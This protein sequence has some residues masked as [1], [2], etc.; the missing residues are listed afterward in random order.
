[1]PGDYGI[2]TKGTGGTFTLQETNG[3]IEAFNADGTLNDIQ[4]TNGNRITA[5]YTAGRLTQPGGIERRSATNPVVAS[6]TIG[7]NTAGLIASVASSDGRTVTYTYDSGEH[8][9]TVT[10]FD[11]EVTQYTYQARIESGDQD[12]LTS[13]SSSPMGRRTT[14][15]TMRRASWRRRRRP[16]APIR[17]PT[18]TKWAK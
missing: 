11:G 8:L 15:A 7:Y 18:A 12:A 1:M 13:R 14:S 4:D 17:S 10:S 6:L 2:L 5:G 16:A 3:Q 9:N